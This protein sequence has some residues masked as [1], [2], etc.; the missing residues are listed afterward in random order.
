MVDALGGAGKA[1]AE[2]FKEA[3]KQLKN[4]DQQISRFEELRQ[5]LDAQDLTVQKP[6]METRPG[7]Q[8]LERAQSVQNDNATN[9]LD[10]AQKVA[11]I[12]KVTNMDG[13][14]KAVNRLKTG[15]DRLKELISSA[16]SGKTFSPQELIGLQAE[17]SQITSEISLASKIVEQG[18]SSFK[19]TM[20]MQV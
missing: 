19:S 5:K 11:D 2:L 3:S 18:V 13:L 4:A 7:Q 10:K 15:Q 17:I 20:Q 9:P 14:E 16:T 6:N 1:G 8:G 12:P